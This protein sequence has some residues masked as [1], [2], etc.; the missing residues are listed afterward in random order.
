MADLKI[1]QGASPFY[2]AGNNI[3]CL[4]I[5]GF[6]GSPYGVRWL[7]EHLHEQGDYTVFG[8]RL[9]GHGTTPDDLAATTWREWYFSALSGYHLL[10]DHCDHVFVIGLSM[11]AVLALLLAAEES[12]SA[13]VSMS[14]PYRVE[15]FGSKLLPI[16]SVIGG[17]RPKN[18]DPEQSERLRKQIAQE[19]E[20]RGNGRFRAPGYNVWPYKAAN[21]L[22]QLLME[23]RS[24]VPFISAPTLLIH[25][26]QD[27]TVPY[28][29]MQLF[30]DALTTA[31]KRCLTL[32]NSGH[33]ITQDYERH[34]VF[35]AVSKFISENI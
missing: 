35:D 20:V 9:A 8:P 29:H 13:V 33:V 23:V 2:F 25:A 6:T 10:R 11:G 4:V 18:L 21:Q 34:I 28:E 3:G 31:D 15:S 14:A 17:T 22:T 1:Q 7:G 24:R 30:Y 32:E 27:Q 26:K 12:V 16:A 5:H 19:Q